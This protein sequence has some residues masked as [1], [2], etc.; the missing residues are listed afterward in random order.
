MEAALFTLDIVLLIVLIRAV[1][2]AD[3]APAEKRHLGI[4]S[5][6]DLK[7]DQ[8]QKGVLGRKGKSGA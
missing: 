8:V 7:T 6:L 3:Q 4:F 2:K 1:C 5:Y